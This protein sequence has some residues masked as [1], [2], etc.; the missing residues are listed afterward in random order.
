MIKIFFAFPFH[1]LGK[2]RTFPQDMKMKSENLPATNEFI[3]INDGFFLLRGEV[4][5]FE[6]RPQIIYPPEPAALPTSV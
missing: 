4:V 5:M 1:F 3:K 2:I 6:F